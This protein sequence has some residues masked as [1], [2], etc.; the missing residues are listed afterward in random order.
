MA[1]LTRPGAGFEADAA[2][3]SP[4]SSCSAAGFNLASL[5]VVFLGGDLSSSSVSSSMS[6]R[7]LFDV[8]FFGG[9]IPPFRPMKEGQPP[10][11]ALL[12]EM[13]TLALSLLQDSCLSSSCSDSGW[14]ADLGSEPLISSF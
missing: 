1:G 10:L 9:A 7:I 12:P 6:S 8:S 5:L 13:D 14:K 2:C 11:L 3:C 4:H